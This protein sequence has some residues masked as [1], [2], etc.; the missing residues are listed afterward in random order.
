MTTTLKSMPAVV[1]CHY[2]L[3]AIELQT[4]PIPEPEFGQVR[5]LVTAS[6]LNPMDWHLAMGSPGIVRLVKGFRR[7]KHEILGREICGVVD[8]IESGRTVGKIAVAID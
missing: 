6:S 3:D 2:G 7:P 1:Q 8:R 4:R 5:I